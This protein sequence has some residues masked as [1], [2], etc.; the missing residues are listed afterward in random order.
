MPGVYSMG[1]NRRWRPPIPACPYPG[2]RPKTPDFAAWNSSERMLVFLYGDAAAARPAALFGSMIMDG[3]L[4]GIG[5]WIRLAAPALAMTAAAS[6]ALAQHYG[7]GGWG[8]HGW[9]GGSRFGLSVSIGVP[10]YRPAPVYC[11]PPVIY[12]E[13][14]YC[15]PRV[16]YVEP[17]PTVVYAPAPAPQPTVV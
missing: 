15:P 5:G 4:F 8:H 16:V 6:P 11:E 2:E 9:G 13:P 17:Q 10:I 3:T 14:V 1:D 7:R 12:R